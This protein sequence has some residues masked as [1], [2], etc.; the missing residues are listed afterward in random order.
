[1]SWSR[2][3][4]AFLPEAGGYALGHGARDMLLCTT[5]DFTAFL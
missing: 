2:A 5:A 4:T 1:V 3:A